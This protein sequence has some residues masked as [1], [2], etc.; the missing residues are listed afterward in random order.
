MRKKAFITGVT[1]QDG[2]YLSEF[3]L[4]KGYDVVGGFRRLSSPSFT[5]LDELGIKNELKL[6]ET[7]LLDAS[8]L[9]RV[10]KEERPTEVYN[11]AAQSFVAHSFKNPILTGN[12]TGMGVTNILEAVRIAD[13]N[14]RF[15]QASTSELFGNA[16]QSP[17]NEE[18]PFQ[19]RSPYGVAK[20][21]GHWATLNY[22][23]S[24]HIFAV[25]GILFN[26]ESPLRGLEFVTR[27]ITNAVALISLGKQDFFEI[28]NLDVKRDWGYAKEYVEAMWMM[29]QT[30]KPENYVLATGENHTVREWIETSF[31]KVGINISWEGE[32]ENE[33]GYDV[34][35]GNLL[36]KVNPE[37]FRPAEIYDLVGDYSKIKRELGW[38]PKVKFQELVDIM[39]KADLEKNI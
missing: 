2:A 13:D 8:N 24:Y 12:V 10:I 6:V 5:R 20:Q 37:F 1:G 3:L 17:Q 38:K 16:E 19:P 29:L 28:G 32:N 27:K 34:K 11:L 26:H 33:K 39:L 7:D 4:T 22:R 23:D 35:S 15:Y 9:I 21:Y 36:V 30:D 25:A 14:I 18:T 31:S